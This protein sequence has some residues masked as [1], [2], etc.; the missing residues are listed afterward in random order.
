M[1]SFEILQDLETCLSCG[2]NFKLLYSHLKRSKNCQSKYDMNDMETKKK[3]E[4][5][6][7]NTEYIS[8]ERT[9]KRKIDEIIFKKGI[10]EEKANQRNIK[11]KEDKT[12]FKKGRAQEKAQEILA[13]QEED[14]AKFKRGMADEKAKE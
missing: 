3:T 5:T 13:K 9:E 2:K 12:S 14:I 7:Y 4:R 11:R 8:N 6:K 10:A 1:N